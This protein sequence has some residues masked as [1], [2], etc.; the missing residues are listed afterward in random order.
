MIKKYIMIKNII[1]EN[2]KLIIESNNNDIYYSDIIDGSINF[3]IYN[4]N[5]KIK[6]LNNIQIKDR[7][8]IYY[9]EKNII[10]KIKIQ[11]KYM[12]NSSSDISD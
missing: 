2:N 4:I 7:I 6:N 10:K 9:N 8:K 11:N 3:N 1:I 12:F 5:N